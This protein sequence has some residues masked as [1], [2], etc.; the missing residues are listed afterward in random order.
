MKNDFGHEKLKAYPISIKFVAV[1]AQITES[2]P[3][4]HGKLVDQLNRAAISIP[5][6]IAEGSGRTSLGD[7]KRFY[8]IARGSAMECVA[9]LDVMRELGLIDNDSRERG[10]SL[11]HSVV[12]IL[13]AICR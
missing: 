9:I 1:V 2:A 12:R 5:L 10:R 4:G 6:N 13:S 11:L 7:R 8:A 3:R